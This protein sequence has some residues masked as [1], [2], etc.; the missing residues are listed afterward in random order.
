[1][2]TDDDGRVLSPGSLA[3]PPTQPPPAGAPCPGP[4]GERAQW[5][6]YQPFQPQPP[7]L[8]GTTATASMSKHGGALKNSR[9]QSYPASPQDRSSTPTVALP[10]KYS[11]R[12]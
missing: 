2:V 5:W 9:W 10:P 11:M 4:T 12:R 1:L 3:R 7:P 6:W 8:A